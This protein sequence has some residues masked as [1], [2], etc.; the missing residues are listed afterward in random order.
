MHYSLLQF[1]FLTNSCSFLNKYVCINTSVFNS[2]YLVTIPSKYVPNVKNENH[3]SKFKPN[4]KKWEWF[5]SKK[6]R[7][8][9]RGAYQA[10]IIKCLFEKSNHETLLSPQKLQLMSLLPEMQLT[11]L[12]EEESRDLQ[13]FF[14]MAPIVMASLPNMTL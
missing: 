6:N 8:I 12:V 1:Q 2:K 13:P 3:F 14:F 11:I 10:S 9:E 4:V 5:Y 7:Y